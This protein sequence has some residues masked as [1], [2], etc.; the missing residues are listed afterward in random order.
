LNC[1]K[2]PAAPRHGARGPLVLWSRAVGEDYVSPI[3][4][5]FKRAVDQPIACVIARN[6]LRRLWRGRRAPGIRMSILSEKRTK[7]TPFPSFRLDFQIFASETG[8]EFDIF[9]FESSW[10][11]QRVPPFSGIS[12][13]PKSLRNIRG[14]SG[15]LPVSAKHSRGYV[16]AER[17][18]YVRS[19][20][21]RISKIRK[22]WAETRFALRR[23][24]FRR[25]VVIFEP[26]AIRATACG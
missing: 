3:R 11:S 8:S 5:T 18:I 17:P 19:L 16:D 22:S 14:L 13:L 12:D 6:L 15:Q 25:M 2:V 10:S 1:S 21:L 9:E 7:W 4:M 24:R 23:D 26:P 20:R